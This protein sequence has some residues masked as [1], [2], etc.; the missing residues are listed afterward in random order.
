MG[1]SRKIFKILLYPWN[2]QIL[3]VLSL[4]LYKNR[5]ERLN[6]NLI[7]QEISIL[8]FFQ[9]YSKINR[10]QSQIVVETTYGLNPY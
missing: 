6:N 3:K 10:N 8:I 5:A 2:F 1:Y 4:E 7:L 9:F